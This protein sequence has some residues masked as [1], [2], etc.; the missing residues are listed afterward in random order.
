[1]ITQ[2]RQRFAPPIYA[3][4]EQTR[5]A[6]L[7]NTILL[8]FIT[9][10]TLYLLA[11][12]LMATDPLP[13]VALVG[14]QVGLLLLFYWWMQQGQV[15]RTSFWLVAEFWLVTTFF[16]IY[17]GG[18]QAASAG[19]YLLCIILAGLLLG[20]RTALIL[21]GLSSAVRLGFIW[22]ARFDLLPPVTFSPTPGLVWL[23]ESIGY[24]FA[25]LLLWLAA[26][27]LT[28]A[29]LNQRRHAQELAAS[30]QALQVSEAFAQTI[31]NSLAPHIAVLGREGEIVA[32][33]QA[34][35]RFAQI[36][37][38]G[39]PAR[40]GIGENYLAVC[41]RTT[42]EDAPYALA[43]AEGI[44][45]V[46]DGTQPSFTLEY[47][48]F[49]PTQQD[50]FILSV[51][52]LDSQQGGA[53]VSH[54]NIT[55]RKHMEERLQQ[56]E[57]RYRAL[58]E[59]IPDGILRVRRDGV[60]LAVTT[61]KGFQ[62]V[63]AAEQVTGR[64]LAEVLPAELAA[65]LLAYNEAA[66]STKRMQVFEFE[67]LSKGVRVIREARVAPID[68][69]EVITLVRDITERKRAEEDTARLLTEVRQQREQLQVLNRRLAET[70]DMERK[71]LARELHD[72]IGSNL[73]LLAVNLKIVQNQ[74]TA[75]LPSDA[76]AHSQFKA[77]QSLLQ[78]I[79]QRTRD[80]MAELWPPVLDDYGLLA[81]LE[82][83]TDRLAAH[84]QLVF[85]VQGNDLESRP[86]AAVEQ[87]LF[88]IAQ[89]ALTNVVKHAQ[90]SQVTIRLNATN[91]TLTLIII[92]NGRGMEPTV[93][94]R[95]SQGENW[96]LL[97]M[98]ER[99]QAIGGNLRIVSQPG[100]GASIIVELPLPTKPNVQTER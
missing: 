6:A 42:G 66:I 1:M 31:L 59:A 100:E 73:S 15:Q 30:N 77:L 9:V 36:N 39:P 71:T 17:G 46:L 44:Q 93:Y 99:A 86:S 26:R 38:G 58:I 16:A 3:D 60:H 28:I 20:G 68:E 67:L 76:P 24:S 10:S 8:F 94:N 41:R 29:R 96:G 21:A 78:Q 62:A 81:A 85:D 74:Y 22:A 90:A 83:Y 97:N 92:D 50:W 43:A 53:V 87:A 51:T 48:C 35:S 23:S 18:L 55:D 70:Q 98:H 64:S 72:Q 56:S 32:V 33:N 57:A 2:L 11:T 84:S 13:R 79:H 25:A 14:L 37:Q 69:Q 82:W 5:L 45:A 63:N 91:E 40:T 27:G 19:N 47:P 65:K 95:P 61:P 7:L 4:E 89:E 75:G 52:P 80:M 49:G 12:P 88:R 34:W 54:L